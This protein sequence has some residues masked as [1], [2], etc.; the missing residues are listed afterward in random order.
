MKFQALD[1]KQRLVGSKAYTMMIDPLCKD[2]YE[3]INQNYMQ[4]ID[5]ALCK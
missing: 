1:A 2:D 3:I 4:D 5:R